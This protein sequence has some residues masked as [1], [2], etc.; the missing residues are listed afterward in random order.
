LADFQGA[1]DEHICNQTAA[2]SSIL[3]KGEVI[4]KHESALIQKTRRLGK[5]LIQGINMVKRLNKKNAIKRE[6]IDAQN[7]RLQL[8]I[9]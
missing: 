2:L 5:R 3:V 7:I 1:N 9:R 4:H 6:V 8:R